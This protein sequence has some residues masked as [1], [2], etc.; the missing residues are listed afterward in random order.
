MRNGLL[1]YIIFIPIIYLGIITSIQDIKSGKIY[2]RHV[3]LG[4]GVGLSWYAMLAFYYGIL[5]GDTSFFSEDIPR[6]LLAT[7]I[8]LAISFGM[9]YFNVWSA[10]DAKLYT[11]FS[12]LMPLSVYNEPDDPSA[13]VILLVNSYAF[14]FA[15]IS[16]D[17]AIRLTRGAWKLW[18][19]FRAKVGSE[20]LES[21]GKIGLM[22]RENW[23]SVVKTFLGIAFI[24]LLVRIARGLVQ[25]E[26]KLIIDIKDSLLFLM[27]FLV[28]RPL[29]LLFQI[30]AVAIVVVIALVVYLAYLL[31]LDPTGGKLFETA[32]VGI[33]ALALITFRQIYSS[34][35]E[36]VEVRHISLEELHP[37]MIITDELK[38]HMVQNELLTV[39]EAKEIGVEGLSEE[40]VIRFKELYKDPEQPG[41]IEV[42]NTIPFAPFIFAGMLVTAIVGGVLIKLGG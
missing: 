18:Q 38:R 8:A 3:L 33:Y 10:A 40:L 36:M 25:D 31:Q 42:E 26:L 2:N 22:V 11:V 7:L 13:P 35:S 37:R 23:L 41:F 14:A 39:E 24:L 4:I 30:R 6:V 17:F 32:D 9:W 21:L 5:A 19:S 27:L 29:H 1:E 20:R 28:F 16:G 34:W 15:F 12:F